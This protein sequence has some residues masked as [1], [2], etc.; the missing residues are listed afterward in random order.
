MQGKPTFFRYCIFSKL[1]APKPRSPDTDIPNF[2]D[3]L[4]K[5]LT[6]YR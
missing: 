2:E 4:R 1:P 6:Q 5:E 3:N